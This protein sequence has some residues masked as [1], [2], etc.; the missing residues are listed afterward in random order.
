MIERQAREMLSGD[1]DREK[2]GDESPSRAGE[3]GEE[4][5][6]KEKEGEE[7]MDIQVKDLEEDIPLTKSGYSVPPPY[8]PIKVA[9]QHTTPST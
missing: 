9:P 5:E 2:S 6:G 7:E 4:G 1:P 3:E 8:P